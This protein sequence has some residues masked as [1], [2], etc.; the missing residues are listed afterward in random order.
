MASPIE[1]R[2]VAYHRIVRFNNSYGIR[3]FCDEQALNSSHF[4]TG[5]SAGF[6]RTLAAS[7]PPRYATTRVNRNGARPV[8]GLLEGLTMASQMTRVRAHLLGPTLAPRS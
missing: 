1:N 5:T 6:L 3:H 7:R 8:Q 4:L 2:R